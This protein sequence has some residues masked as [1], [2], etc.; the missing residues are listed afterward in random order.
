[1]A[2]PAA[3]ARHGTARHGRAHHGRKHHG[4]THHVI[5]ENQAGALLGIRSS[6][7]SGGEACVMG[8]K[9]RCRNG[10]AKASG[11]F[12]ARDAS[13]AMRRALCWTRRLRSSPLSIN[14]SAC[15][16]SPA[17]RQLRWGR[18][19]PG[20]ADA[21]EECTVERCC[22]TRLQESPCKSESF[23]G[24]SIN[25]VGPGITSTAHSAASLVTR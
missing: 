18:V 3:T 14:T 9:D 10:G 15:I 11:M 6:F 24:A 20:I 7:P 23:W 25:N 5:N 21:H 22:V 12:M 19:R 1:M 16:S 4:R 8:K 2:T 13:V 17:V